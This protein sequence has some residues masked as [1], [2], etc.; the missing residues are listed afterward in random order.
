MML[1]P[2]IIKESIRDH[3][4]KKY[5]LNILFL[6]NEKRPVL[7]NWE[8]LFKNMQT[9]DDIKKQYNPSA[10]MYSYVCGWNELICIEFNK[11]LV[12]YLAKK[13]FKKRLDT[14]TVR[15]PNRGYLLFFFSNEANQNIDRFVDNL[16]VNFIV[17]G[18][19]PVYGLVETAMGLDSYN[20]IGDDIR[21]D[22]K[23]ITD[24]LDFLDKTIAKLSFLEYN[25]V[26]QN[27][28]GER[29]YLDYHQRLAFSNLIMHTPLKISEA[30]HFFKFC[31]DYD[32]K[33]I[34]HLLKDTKKKIREGE[35]RPI[36]CKRLRGILKVD[37]SICDGCI[38]H[39]QHKE[40]KIAEKKKKKDG[41]ESVTIEDLFN[42]FT[43]KRIKIGTGQ[44]FDENEKKLYFSWYNPKK[45]AFL[46]LS[47][48][49]MNVG[50]SDE[51]IKDW[52][53]VNPEIIRM[54]GAKIKPPKRVEKVIIR[55][56]KDWNDNGQLKRRDLTLSKVYDEVY[57]LLKKYIF[58]KDERE[59]NLLSLWIMGTYLRQ[60]FIWYPYIVLFGLRN[61]G[62]ST[63]LTFLSK[64]C[65]QGAGDI[66][67]DATE[68]VMFRKASG[69]KGIMFIE[70]YEEIL[71]N[72]IKDQMYR[73][74]LEN[75]WYRDS[76]VERINKDT[77]DVDSFNA[78]VPIAVGTREINEVL[79]E[80]GIV[81]LMEE[82]PKGS[83]YAKNF[84]QI[85]SDPKFDEISFKCHLLALD[86]AERVY[87]EY[88]NLAGSKGY[89]EINGRDWNKLSPFLAMAR[90]I[91]EE[92][93]SDTLFK[94][95][96]EY[97]VLY[98][99]LRKQDSLELEDNVLQLIVR[100][101]LREL[102]VSDIQGYL[103]EELGEEFTIQKISAI[104]QKLQGI[105]KDKKRVDGKITY[106]IDLKLA[107]KK[108][109]QRGLEA[110][111]GDSVNTFD[112][113]DIDETVETIES[114]ITEPEPMKEH[115]KDKEL[116]ETEKII[117]RVIYEEMNNPN[118]V[119]GI[120]TLLKCVNGKLEKELTIEDIQEK[121][122]DL[123][124][125]KLIE[126]P[127][128]GYVQ[129]SELKLPDLIDEGIILV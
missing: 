77:M 12:Y 44:Y 88:M 34:I 27:L 120:G 63:T 84:R 1:E 31:F 67:A 26:K 39:T 70:H 122:A 125:K 102:Q 50:I 40:D 3:L 68:A 30:K 36:T 6:D 92:R 73:Q 119:C 99:K 82:A 24:F 9:E 123:K 5:N 61:V 76:T 4:R 43:E 2:L 110:D 62:K 126:E 41:L 103:K 71:E 59:Y 18:Y 32:E 112:D 21:R 25:C 10:S 54:E 15:V 118:Q 116:S 49:G 46:V 23:I 48:D 79:D 64:S 128:L 35:L 107:M 52:S 94:E 109:I 115:K 83:D 8:D 37:R 95:L 113:E 124:L 106:Y 17:R 121:I 111:I 11:P 87:D 20:R 47:S 74:Y 91:D 72:P 28:R 16:Q 93:G 55:A 104:M 22:N 60:V 57:M 117:L 42:D 45:K 100:E 53:K 65:F 7:E 78:S 80:K 114:E 85:G 90:I 38:R 96:Y 97:G 108:A 19:A 58:L 98:S 14:L 105:L 29:N 86:Y 56:L 127:I 129:I 81:I 89:T 66:S 51:E 33:T 101:K 13:H 75:A 69:L